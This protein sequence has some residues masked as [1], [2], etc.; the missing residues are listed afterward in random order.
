MGNQHKYVLPD[1]CSAHIQHTVAKDVA[2]NPLFGYKSC[3]S[4][5]SFFLISYLVSGLQ[6]IL[7]FGDMEYTGMLR[8]IPTRWLF[9]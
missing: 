7:C 9:P 2:D 1:T 3:E 4:S 6:M 8:C 5:Q